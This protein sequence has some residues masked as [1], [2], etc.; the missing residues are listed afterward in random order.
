MNVP[1]A[2][3]GW[4][5]DAVVQLTRVGRCEGERHDF[6]LDLPASEN[7]TKLACAFANSQGGF[8]VVGV[9]DRS[10]HFVVEGIAPDG[11]IAKKFADKLRATPSVAFS[12]PRDIEIPDSANVLYVFH[13][14]Q[15]PTRPHISGLPGKGSFWKRTPG[16][17]EQMT[18]EEIREQ[19]LGYEERRDKL[20]LLFL[21]LILN[22]EHLQEMS[23]SKEDEYSLLT[24]D[25]GVLDRLLVDAYSVVK[26]DDRLIQIL[27][28]LRTNI[29]VMNTKSQIFW[30][31][32]HSGGNE[33]GPHRGTGQGRRGGSRWPGGNAHGCESPRPVS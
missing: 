22:R 5:Y 7:L 27:L 29:R 12:G 28:T 15:S 31:F 18:Y 3:E 1:V 10:G 23:A 4:T 11:E 21:E 6:K 16:G 20:K 14:P 9:K 26:A 25:S 13:V 17:C 32:R 30:L 33:P 24:L 19:F 2:L 8:V